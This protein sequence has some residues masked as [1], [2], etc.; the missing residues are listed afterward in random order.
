MRF[1]SFTIDIQSA[2][3][4]SLTSN[5][6][7]FLFGFS[8]VSDLNRMINAKSQ[9]RTGCIHGTDDCCFHRESVYLRFNLYISH[10]EQGAIGVLDRQDMDH[11][12]Q[13]FIDFQKRGKSKDEAGA[14]KRVCM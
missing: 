5:A 7:I 10:S 6:K 13:V 2:V 3:I 12:A 11:F 1:F 9:R 4:L 8:R 14:F